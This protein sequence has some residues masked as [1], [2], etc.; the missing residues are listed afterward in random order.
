MAAWTPSQITTAVWHQADAITGLNDAD[1]IGTW[2]DSSGN[3]L[4]ATAAAAARPTYKTSILNSLPVARFSSNGMDAQFNF[5]AVNHFSVAF[6]ATP[7]SSLL[8]QSVVR[9]QHPT[10]A[11][12]FTQWQDGA[13]AER[14]ISSWDGGTTG[15]NLGWTSGS[16]LITYVREKNVARTA[17]RDGTQSGTNVASNTNL[18]G[19]DATN[20]G[21]GFRRAHAT[22]EYFGGDIAEIIIAYTNWDTATRQKVEGYLAW[23]WGL[24]ANLPGA[25]PYAGFAPTVGNRSGLRYPIGSGLRQRGLR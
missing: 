3:G 1:P 20:A 2:V 9:Q 16:T 25:H 8:F 7:T 14:I 5:A 12:Y 6:V 22:P 11:D 10:N 18:A 15:E 23:K 21:I 4:S 24:Q 17:W 13:G 19:V